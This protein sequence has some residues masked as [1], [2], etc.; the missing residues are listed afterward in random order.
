MVHRRRTR[1]GH[2]AAGGARAD[3]AGGGGGAVTGAGRRADGP[4]WRQGGAPQLGAAAC[5]VGRVRGVGW[6]A[7]APAGSHPLPTRACPQPVSTSPSAA[8]RRAESQY[9]RVY[10]LHFSLRA[11]SSGRCECVC[12][13]L[14]IH[15]WLWLYYLSKSNARSTNGDICDKGRAGAG[16]GGAGAARRPTRRALRGRHPARAGPPAAAHAHAGT[17]ADAVAA[18]RPPLA[19]APLAV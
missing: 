14:H 8:T 11:R 13:S 6:R 4:R 5:A 19:R 3:G 1:V 16:G 10:F 2:V 17:R 7:R 18:G 15:V 12:S 9:P